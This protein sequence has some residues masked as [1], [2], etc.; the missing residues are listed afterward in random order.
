MKNCESLPAREPAA[1]QTRS[2]TNSPRRILVV[3]D[4]V[5]VRLL[6]KEV[7]IHHGFQVDAAE[8]GAAG[9]E[10]LHAKQY[11][12]LITDNNMPKVTGIELVK[13]LRADSITLPVIM[14]SGTIP[15][16]LNQNPRLLN[17]ALLKPFT[18]KELLETVNNV[19]RTTEN[20]REQIHSPPLT[21]LQPSADASGVK[22]FQSVLP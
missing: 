2:G 11:D 9:L 13:K 15:E 7:L 3:D 1:A 10:A 8:D 19:L 14:A 22:R 12:L 6:S 16:E 18:S 20:P 5:T 4:D 17:A 21:E